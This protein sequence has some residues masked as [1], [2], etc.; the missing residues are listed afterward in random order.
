[1]ITFLSAP[2]FDAAGSILI[3]VL[4]SSDFGEVS[5]RAFRIPTT[6]GN[7]V[8]NDFGFS[9]SDRTFRINWLSGPRL[10][11]SIIE[12]LSIS[13]PRLIFS[14]HL[15]LFSVVPNNY[16]ISNGQSELTLLVLEKL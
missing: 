3:D 4:P 12:Y 6:D 14:C 9:H 15:G 13:Y 11:E 7:A 10:Y 1:M 16:R 5:R 2:T 8:V